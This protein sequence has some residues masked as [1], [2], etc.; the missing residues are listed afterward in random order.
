LIRVIRVPFPGEE[1]STDY[2]DF[3]GLKNIRENPFDPRHPRS[4]FPMAP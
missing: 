2:A 1:E 3:A 4:I